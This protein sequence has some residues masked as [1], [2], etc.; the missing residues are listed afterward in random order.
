MQKHKAELSGAASGS[1]GKNKEKRVIYEIFSS[2]IPENSVP[3]WIWWM[4][5]EGVPLGDTLGNGVDS[6]ADRE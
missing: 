5:K 6:G 4:G 2:P 1:S 3:D